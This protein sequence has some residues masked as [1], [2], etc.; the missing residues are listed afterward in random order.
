VYLEDLTNEQLE[1]ALRQ[2]EWR[3]APA[4]GAELHRVNGVIG[5][6]V[7]TGVDL[8]HWFERCKILERAQARR[9]DVWESLAAGPADFTCGGI[10]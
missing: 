1:E 9:A 6:H 2:P 4:I 8:S 10:V 5:D 3:N 7:L